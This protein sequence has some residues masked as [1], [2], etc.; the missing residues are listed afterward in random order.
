MPL[1]APRADLIVDITGPVGFDMISRQGAY[2]LADLVDEGTNTIRQASATASL[3]S[4]DLPAHAS[5][6]ST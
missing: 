6:R 2:R 5:K 1:A 4:S 3:A